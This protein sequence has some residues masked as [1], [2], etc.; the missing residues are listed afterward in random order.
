MVLFSCWEHSEMK[1]SFMSLRE[2][3]LPHPAPEGAS[4]LVLLRHPGKH[5]LIRI[6]PRHRKS[7]LKH[8]ELLLLFQFLRVGFFGR[9]LDW[10]GLFCTRTRV[11][12]TMLEVDEGFF[13]QRGEKGTQRRLQFLHVQRILDARLSFLH[14]GNARD[15][16]LA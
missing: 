3:G 14:G 13:T 2:I 6:S 1:N 9:G 11:D 10:L 5:A 15:L 4:S 16:M 7:V 8:A 12:V